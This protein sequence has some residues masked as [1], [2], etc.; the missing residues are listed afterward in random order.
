VSNHYFAVKWLKAF[1][2]S[3]EDV[4]ALYA[5]SFS[6]TDPILDQHGIKD[7]Q[8]LIRLFAP[9]ANKD[10]SNGIGIHNFRVDEV[11][12]DHK[13]AIYR[14]T[15]R[16]QTA[17]AFLG[18]PTPDQQ[19]GSRGITFHIYA[20]NGLITREESYWDAAYALAPYVK[21]INPSQK[22]KALPVDASKQ[23][24]KR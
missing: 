24:G 1:R 23:E 9:Y 10:A 5:D 16:A 11:V 17:Q 4:T 6:F 18:V 13:A 21:E 20:D 7:R 3:A 2:T 8:E 19:P 14:W 12:G 22:F 15:W